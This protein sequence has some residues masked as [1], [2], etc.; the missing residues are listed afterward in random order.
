MFLSVLGV[1]RDNL[2]DDRMELLADKGH[3]NYAY[4]DSLKEARKVLVD[5]MSSTLVTIAKDVKLQVE[6]NPSEVEA[7][8]QI[9]YENR[10]IPH[11]DFNN[12]AKD[13]G[14]VG[15]G[16]SSHGLSTRYSRRT[17]L[18][19]RWTTASPRW[20]PSNTNNRGNHTESAAR[21]RSEPHR[22]GE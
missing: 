9:G 22:G 16:H 11:Q 4:I 18:P 13:A 20:I 1:G 2:K 5:Q 17:P 12:D 21:E 8:R 15:A 3:G 10:E 7:F 14:D 19:S 6:F